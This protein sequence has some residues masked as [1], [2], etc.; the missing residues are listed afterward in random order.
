MM[1]VMLLVTLLTPFAMLATRVVANP[2]L[3]R[4]TSGLHRLLVTKQ[5]DPNDQY[6]LA[7]NDRR[8]LE[9]LNQPYSSPSNDT[10]GVLPLNNTG[11]YYVA[12]VGVGNP[13]TNCILK[14]C[15]AWSPI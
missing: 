6:D 3:I 15:L 7:Q 4:D 12:S 11:F 10:T 1:M 14:F 2:L 8:H 5:I 9:S 13:P